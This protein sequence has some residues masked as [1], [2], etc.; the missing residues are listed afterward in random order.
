M[1]FAH[2]PGAL[3]DG[4]RAVRR[5]VRHRRR[6]VGQV[7]TGVAPQR[8]LQRRAGA[9]ATRQLLAALL[10]LRGSCNSEMSLQLACYQQPTVSQQRCS[11]FQ[12]I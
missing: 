1:P 11:V 3:S 4:Q 6:D 2:L 8:R 10:L 12:Q 7:V 9:A 5:S